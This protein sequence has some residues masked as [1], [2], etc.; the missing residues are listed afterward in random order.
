[1]KDERAAWQKWITVGTFVFYPMKK[2]GRLDVQPME[3]TSVYSQQ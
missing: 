2:L 3:V 1:M